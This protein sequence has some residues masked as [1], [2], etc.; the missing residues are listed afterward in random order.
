MP[1]SP[2]RP[3]P[4]PPPGRRRASTPAFGLSSTAVRRGHAQGNGTGNRLPVPG[5]GISV[6]RASFATGSRGPNTGTWTPALLCFPQMWGAYSY[7]ARVLLLVMLVPAFGPMAMPCAV[8]PQ[9]VAPGR[10]LSGPPA[11]PGMQCHHARA[12]S[13][14]PQPEK[15]PA[16]IQAADNNDDCCHNHCCC[17]AAASEWARPAP[18]L[19]TRISLA[20]ESA[21]PLQNAALRS[22]AVARQDSARAP[23]HS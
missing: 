14:P 13:N 19:P 17:G 22:N 8:L 18:N 23:P 5:R 6:S 11:Q 7:A 12:Q 4:P 3:K 10:V 21:R 9:A 1:R 16:S 20:I 2:P 15:S